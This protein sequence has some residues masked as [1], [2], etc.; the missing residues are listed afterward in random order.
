MDPVEANTS[1]IMD[2]VEANTISTAGIVIRP[3]EKQPE[4]SVLEYVDYFKRVKK[5]N[6]WSDKDAGEIFCAL[7]GPADRTIDSLQEKWTT[8]SELEALLRSKQEPM[9]DANLADLMQLEMKEYESV[10]NLRNRVMHLV[11]LVYGRF[12]LDV[13][14]Q[15]A[16]DFF[17]HALPREVKMHVLGAR[18]MTLDDTV[19]IAKSSMLMSDKSVVA[20]YEPRNK[21][22]NRESTASR[23][24]TAKSESKKS[25]SEIQCF[26]CK[27][28][29]HI[30][31]NCP[32]KKIAGVQ[33]L[34]VQ[35][36]RNDESQSE[37]F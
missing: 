11:S 21:E 25:V 5:V 2:P 7:L 8:F 12:S 17:L 33:V 20:A 18:T 31:R 23:V 36:E 10:D 34:D 6:H 30:S 1:S 28:Y 16:R 26:K 35:V 29:G 4:Q 9:R 22:R 13:Q 15:I 37:N 32:S 24:S 14:T 19:N 3:K 27:G